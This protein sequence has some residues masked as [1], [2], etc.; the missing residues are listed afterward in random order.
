MKKTLSLSL[1]ALLMVF[2]LA[3]CG[4]RSQEDVVDSLGE[5]MDK[6]T[7]YKADAKMTLNTGEKPITYDIEIWH[8]EPYFYRVSL[9]NTAKDQSQMILRNKEGVFV[10]TP[11]LNKSFRFQSDWPENNSQVYLFESL[12]ADILNDSDRGFKEKNDNYVFN[13]KTNYQNKNLYQ[14]EIT[15]N[16]DLEPKMVRVMDKDQK[17]LVKLEFSNVEFNAKFDKS[18]F[19]MEKNM[20]GAQMKTPVMA[21]EDGADFEV[22]YPTYTPDGME[23]ANEREVGIEDG[24]KVVLNYADEKNGKSFTLIQQ[25][26][27]AI[28]TTRLT[29]TNGEPVDLGF[30]VGAMTDNSI[31]WNDKGID[32]F[33]AS[34]TLKQ[35]EMIS[36]ARSVNGQSVK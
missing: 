5:K 7:G 30:T 21:V 6:M 11:A 23:I 25:K 2:M 22:M 13:T 20:S 10:L 17:E 15:L 29:L 18:A 34:S 31:S 4:S 28:Q 35:E 12:A 3:A 33:L 36:I 16:D 8:K 26:T 1:M 32:Y 9:K 24:S 27:T 14:Q 19:D